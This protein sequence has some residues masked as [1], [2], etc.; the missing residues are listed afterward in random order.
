MT[1]PVATPP[2]AAPLQFDR[3][4]SKD[5]ESKVPGV[6]CAM[7]SKKILERY[8]TLGDQPTCLTC[9]MKVEREQRSSKRFSTFIKA[10]MYGFGAAVA[11]AMVYWAVLKFL[12]LEIGLVAIAIGFAVGY[13]MRKGAK[14]WGGRRYQLVAAGL[15][16]LS[17]CMAYFPLAL[18]SRTSDLDA[19]VAAAD[20]TAASDSTAAADDDEEDP[21]FALGD[22]MVVA[23][24]DTVMTAADSAVAAVAD[25]IRRADLEKAPSGAVA[26]AIGLA[27]VILLALAL[28]ILSI[29]ASLP[30]GLISALIIGFGMKQAWRM[31]EAG[32]LKFDGPLTVAR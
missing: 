18:E 5:G 25:S 23:A 7:C 10:S 13:A 24:Q 20:S 21:A 8:Y 28:P 4:V 2:A 15:T 12:H 22:S 30:M 19:A 26:I 1:E 3:A 9:K 29:I 16:Y 27:A 14:G 32:E 17:V 31:T 6:S 11:G